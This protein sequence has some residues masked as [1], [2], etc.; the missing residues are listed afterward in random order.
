MLIQEEVGLLGVTSNWDGRIS[1]RSFVRGA[2]AAMLVSAGGGLT[3]LG[4]RE[5]QG[6]PVERVEGYGPLVPMGA[7]ALP[8]GFSYK[9]ISQQGDPMDDGNLTPGVFDGMGAFPGPDGT[10][11]L[12]RNHENRRRVGESTVIVPPEL[13]YDDDLTYNAGNTKLVV[14]ENLNVVQDFAILGGTD[15]NCAGGQMPWGSWI[16]C[17]EVVN[18]SAVT[19]TP[20]GY[21]FEIDAYA[22]GPVE[23]RPITAAGRFTHEAVAWLDG[24]LYETEDLRDD[25][26]FYRYIP[27]TAPDSSGDLADSSGLLEALK[28]KDVT[29]AV[30]DTFPTVGESYDVEW[31][32]IDDP[33]PDERLLEPTVGQQARAKGAA[34]F[35]REEGIWVG[36][37]KV[38]FDCTEGGELDLGQVYEFDPLPGRETITLIYEST[39]GATLENPDN[40]VIVPKTG[41]IFLQEDSEDEQFVRGLTPE[42]RIYDF[43]KTITS[44][45][46]FCG[47]CFSPNGTV[48]FLN[49]QGARG[50]LPAGPPNGSAVTYAITGPFSR[51]R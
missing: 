41:D 18:R 30:M 37:D 21:I 16:T 14:D 31:V 51:R 25:S 24:I 35:D 50:S 2:A 38:Y 9:V 36:G 5:A 23:A 8:R 19:S 44:N 28:I 42:G 17:E 34:I 20:H 12:I 40:V 48:F 3:A 7:L 27:S 46:E 45:T 32:T 22:D 39:N 26:F 6:K 49:Q 15:T 13:R 33:D 1:R 29:N 10:T 11:V 4:A 43:A 47:G